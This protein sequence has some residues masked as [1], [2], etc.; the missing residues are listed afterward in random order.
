MV[1]TAELA[2][3]HVVEIHTRSFTP[4]MMGLQVTKQTSRISALSEK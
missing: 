3:D 1:T 4:Y 2:H